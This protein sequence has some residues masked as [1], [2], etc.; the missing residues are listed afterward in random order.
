MKHRFLLDKNIF[1]HAIK[2]V[3]KND[4]P[5]LTCANLILLITSNCHRIVINGFLRSR[6]IFHLNNLMLNRSGVL[7]PLFVLNQLVHNSLKFVPEWEEPPALPSSCRVPDE[8]VNVVRAALI[9]HPKIVTA[10]E[11]LKNA[12][13][14]CEALHLE[15]L[16]PADAIILASEQ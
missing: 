4:I 9:S 2:G 13:N 12:I 6:Y 15:A 5:D 11:D 3:D 10:D 8:D 7:Q 16:S 1:H 14:E